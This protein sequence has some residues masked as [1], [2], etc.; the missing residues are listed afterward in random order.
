[1]PAATRSFE[2]IEVL[3][4]HQVDFIVV[5]MTAAVLQGAPAVTFDLDILYSR[6]PDNIERTL[7][8]L[9]ELEAVF[10]GDDRRIAPN[11]SHLQS[12]G[13]KLLMTKF[14]IVDVLGS[15]GERDYAELLEDTLAL[16]VADMVVR[17]LSLERL[18]EVK[19]EA[20]REKD[21][22][23]LPLLRATLARTGRPGSSGD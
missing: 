4:Q 15:L 11:E 7:A 17:V 2:V 20:G 18:I 19:T 12:R 14:G 21:L 16:D 10:R 9:S 6:S 3:T 8:A 22:A 13:H 23:V 5:G 1:M